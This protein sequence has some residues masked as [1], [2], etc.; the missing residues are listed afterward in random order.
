MDLSARLLRL[1]VLAVSVLMLAGPGVPAVAGGAEDPLGGEVVLGKVAGIKYVAESLAVGTGGTHAPPAE[2][3]SIA[4]GGHASGWHVSVGG[5]R[6]SGGAAS[7]SITTLR[8]LDLD[9]MFESPDDDVPDDW[10][11]ATVRSVVGR[12]LTG[13]ALCTKTTLTYVRNDVPADMTTDRSATVTCP[14]NR[15]LVG[16]GG[17]IATTDSRL[18]SSFPVDDRTWKIRVFDSIG[19]AGGMNG[20]AVC[21]KAGKVSHVSSRTTGVAADTAGRATVMCPASRHV[22]GGGGR[23]SGTVSQGALAESRPVDGKD[24]D[25]VP[26]DG[27]RVVGY[28]HGGAAKTVTASALCVT[29]G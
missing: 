6:M 7:N 27:W 15:H 17:F 10:W 2:Q 5:A 21:R 28:N 18:V 22:I 23:I 9:A 16:G 8:P 20:Y 26:D 11:D 1:P 19:G 4:C 14:A 29:K 25:H 13:Y 3:A 12:T 24:R